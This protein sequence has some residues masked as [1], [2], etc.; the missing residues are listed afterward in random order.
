MT[1]QTELINLISQIID[2]PNMDVPNISKLIASFIDL[3]VFD[4]LLGCNVVN[5]TRFNLK[6]HCKEL[7]ELFV[8]KNNIGYYLVRDNYFINN[9][10]IENGIVIEKNSDVYCCEKRLKNYNN[11]N[12]KH[13]R[14]LVREEAFY[15]GDKYWREN[16][17][18]FFMVK[19]SPEKLIDKYRSRLTYHYKKIDLKNY[20]A[21][22][23]IHN[24]IL[25]YYYDYTIT[26]DKE[27]IPKTFNFLNK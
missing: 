26:E 12:K 2:V 27:E 6:N 22:Y 25:K 11:P 19:M 3:E 5:I 17:S 15:W 14:C 9:L 20:N 24:K 4:T 18:G 13:K 8:I 1:N 10:E 16:Y 21:L 7:T 23:V